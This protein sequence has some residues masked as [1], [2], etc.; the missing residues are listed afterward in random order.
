MKNT[1]QKLAGYLSLTGILGAISS[2][3]YAHP[4]S[5]HDYSF[6]AAILHSIEHAHPLVLI[7]LVATPIAFYI[8]RKQRSN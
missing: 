4:G 2:V 6:I 7:A 1:L 5:H 8:W 3:T